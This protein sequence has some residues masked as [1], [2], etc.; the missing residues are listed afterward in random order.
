MTSSIGHRI[1]LLAPT[2]T[3]ITVSAIAVLNGY[4]RFRMRELL[5]V[6]SGMMLLLIHAMIEFVVFTQL[7]TSD[8]ELANLLISI[9]VPSIVLG[10]M[11]IWI[12]LRKITGEET[13]ILDLIHIV[14]VAYSAG[15]IMTGLD[16][17]LVND[18]FVVGFTPLYLIPLVTLPVALM[19]LR[20][21]YLTLTYSYSKFRQE[22]IMLRVGWGF[23]TSAFIVVM[24]QRIRQEDPFVFF[25][26]YATGLT[27]I[28]LAI[29]KQPFI[30]LPKN[31]DGKYFILSARESGTIL[32]EDSF[33]ED[34]ELGVLSTALRA[35][36]D[37]LAEVSLVTSGDTH[38]PKSVDF[39]GFKISI[40]ETEGF[41]GYFFSRK[42]VDY[43]GVTIKTI[44][45]E[46]ERN[47][48][49]ANVI[50]DEFENELR[51]AL[52]TRLSFALT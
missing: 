12:S 1:F 35:A 42:Y 37:V 43:I 48:N 52:Q 7:S 51:H 15:M 14:S 5:G 40:V 4:R 16:V 46:L 25:I 23:I 38:Y 50:T 2:V 45:Q 30:I 31:I 47:H 21:M 39:L 9:A 19:A 10:I 49:I 29:A 17:Q 8:L 41:V 20:L 6:F 28:A 36:I 22:V 34:K 32:C 44:I 11:V 3:L 27:F 18:E 33:G 26:F 13:R 24:V